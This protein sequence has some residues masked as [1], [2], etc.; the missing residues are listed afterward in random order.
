M[1]RHHWYF[2]EGGPG[3]KP[4]T[5]GDKSLTSGPFHFANNAFSGIDPAKIQNIM[6]K[7]FSNLVASATKALSV[8]GGGGPFSGGERNEAEETDN[9]PEDGE[10]ALTSG[11]K[12]PLQQLSY[13]AKFIG[14][15]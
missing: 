1:T 5:E 8:D 14:T 9:A 13:M 4:A 10:K 12:W 11:R 15:T 6:S 2:T 7:S 3:Q